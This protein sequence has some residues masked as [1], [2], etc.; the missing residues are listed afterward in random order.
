MLGVLLS[1]GIAI[2]ALQMSLPL[3]NTLNDTS[4][5]GN[6]G[7]FPGGGANPFYSTSVI[8]DGL[9]FDGINDYISVNSF[10]PGSTFSVAFWM[11][12]NALDSIDTYIEYVRTNRNNDFF[13]GYDNSLGQLFVELQDNNTSEDGPCGDP[14]FCT[15]ISLNA[16]RWYH[17]TVTV[18]PTTLKTYI[19]GE[20]ASNITH[21][22]TVAF[23][24]GT[25]LIGGDSDSNPSGVADSDFFNGRLDEINIFNHELNQSEI[26]NLMNLSGWWRLDECSLTAPGDVIDSS[27]NTYHGTPANGLD[28]TT[29][30]ICRAGS[31]DGN[32]D[33]IVLPGFPGLTNSFTISA[34]INPDVINKDQRIFADDETNNQ[35][36]AFSLGDGGDGRLRFFSRGVSPISLDST[37][38]ITAGGWFNVVAV[39]DAVAK[40]RQIFVNGAAVTARQTYT[41]TWGQDPGQPSIGGETNNA[42]SE[43][44]ANWRFDGLID[45]VKVYQRALTTEEI[46]DYY[47]Q[48][49][50][51]TRVCPDCGGVTPNDIILSTTGTATLGGLTFT[52]G[53]LAE[54]NAISDTA[55]LFFDENLFSGNED[56]DATHVLPSGNIILSTSG[57]ATLS[58]LTF[59][60]GDLVEYNPLS[61]SATLFFSEDNFSGNEDID[62]VYVRD[63]GNIILSTE[64]TATL[65]GLT[66]RDGDLAEYNPT[67]NTA[68]LFFNENNF[69]GGADINGTHLLSSGNILIT[70]DNTE[71]LGGLTFTDGSIAEYDPGADT[72]TLYFD[73]NLFSG[74]EDINAVTLQLAV[75]QL[76]HI[77]IEHDGTALT[78]N[79]EN[80]TLRACANAVCD[81][82]IGDTVVVGLT[83]TGWVGGDSQSIFSGNTVVQFRRTTPGL[84]TL[85]VSGS[86]PIATNPYECLNTSNASSSCDLTFYDSGFI[87]SIPSQT[88]CTTSAN[89]TVAAVRKDITTQQCI[90]AFANRNESINFWSTYVSPASGSNQLTLNNGTTDF[91]LST[92]TPGTAVSLN[93]DANGEAIISLNY[94]DAGQLTLNSSFSGTGAEADLIMNGATTFAT[95]PAKF[96]VYSPDANSDCAA[97]NLS[98]SR[99]TQAGQ[100]FNLGARAACAD[101]RVTPNFQHNGISITHNLVAPV[102][103][104][105]GTI[106]NSAFDMLVGDNGEHTITDQSVSEVGV[107][108]YSAQ[109]SSGTNYFGA[110]TI[111]TTALNTSVNIGRFYPSYFEVTRIHGCAA[112]AFTYSGQPFSVTATAFNFLGANTQN[113]DG[114][115]AFAFDTTISDD[116][117]DTSNFLNNVIIAG[118]FISGIGARN[119][120]TYTF[121]SVSTPPTNLTLRAIDADSVSSEFHLEES[122]EI[123]SGR[124]TIENAFGSELIDLSVP[125]TVQHYEGTEFV[126]FSADVC[127]TMSL[128]LTKVDGA[129]NVGNGGAAGDTCIWDDAGNSGTNNCSAAA[130]LPGPTLLQYDEPPSAADFNLYLKAPG[131]G[132]TGNVDVSGNVDSWLRFD[133]NGT[134]PADPTGRATF[135]IYRG[136]DRIIYW[137]ERFE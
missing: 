101:D 89:I 7:N 21:S 126:N 109:L 3:D 100:N 127:S 87:Y 104:A 5:N 75:S 42:G 94:P 81:S 38:A 34:W 84:V 64:N 8:N 82:E 99:F 40:T 65:G 68:T 26:S 27:G 70:T 43:A 90:P 76:H 123:H 58:G 77:R 112:G 95:I 97:A 83:P 61:N 11:R 98:C 55:T 115:L 110:T 103:G 96:Y 37:A 107:F 132:F 9:D 28:T 66:F 1:P 106:G 88:S 134:G 4:G 54:Y 35:G 114:S 108:T 86:T 79:P 32:D 93:F 59:R 39:H 111:G 45:E 17:I 53:S 18:T 128:T 14:K 73:E 124:I 25:W 117:G 137:R 122:T 20:L 131:A 10:N 2:A 31:F 130:V 56:V 12:A 80:I 60:D 69:S 33:H 92:S 41:G 49:E 113:Y 62:A 72:A 67:S 29:G 57:G 6:N 118:S 120:V 102:G 24:P 63:N 105:P 74:N 119:D 85:G 51:I 44:V 47:L 16:N 30:R 116:S 121:S 46:S 135:G 91:P 13:V 48:A 23:N 136:D 15:D 71:T 129:L 50:P 133:W 36:F 52:N 78:C 22:T 125:T 19:D